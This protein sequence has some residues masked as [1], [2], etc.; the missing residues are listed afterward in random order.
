MQ[1]Y[2]VGV[3]DL[4][5]LK[6]FYLTAIKRTM[7]LIV[8]PVICILV[9]MK[10][11]ILSWV[12]V[13]YVA[14]IRIGLFLIFSNLFMFISVPTKTFITA[15]EKIRLLYITS[16]LMVIVYWCGIFLTINRWQVESFAIFKFVAL[17]IACLFYLVIA[18]RFLKMNIFHFVKEVILPIVG[19]VLFLIV[20][21]MLIQA[22][23]PAEKGKV[24]LLF[25]VFTGGVFLLLSLVL[26]YLMS[27][28]FKGFINDNVGKIRMKR[29][30]YPNS[31]GILS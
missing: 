5:G 2:F 6:R 15:L 27:K 30:L 25:V 11:L 26:Y 21:L 12:G 13:D 19:P 16:S 28:D 29:K 24:N 8:F 17:M 20:S 10:P 3:N 22:Y 1:P 14:S 23:L 31:G 9:L 4:Q 18:M 7:P